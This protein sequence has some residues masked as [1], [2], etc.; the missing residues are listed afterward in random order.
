MQVDFSRRVLSIRRVQMHRHALPRRVK[1]TI[2][3]GLLNVAR[4]LNAAFQGIMFGLLLHC[5]HLHRA[6]YIAQ[7]Y[8]FLKQVY[9]FCVCNQLLVS[10]LVCI[11]KCQVENVLSTAAVVL[12]YT[13]LD[14]RLTLR[15][16]ATVG[17]LCNSGS[18][19]Q[20]CQQRNWMS[21]TVHCL[22]SITSSNIDWFSKLFH[23]Q[24]VQ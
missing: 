12:Y 8:K 3:F 24:T 9:I 21:L 14:F 6:L 23:Q 19:V 16:C 7:L 20:Q 17:L 1:F 11:F 15:T 5:L 4:A 2:Q 22:L 13:R 18:V 10:I